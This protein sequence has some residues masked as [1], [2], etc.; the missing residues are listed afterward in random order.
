MCHVC[1]N[2]YIKLI[3]TDCRDFSVAS[4]D[5]MK[6]SLPDNFTCWKLTL[7]M[8]QPDALNITFLVVRLSTIIISIIFIQK[9]KSG[10]SRQ[11]IKEQY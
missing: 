2:L 11:M 3:T 8:F 10:K 7:L 1:D 6:G 9:S 5:M 4:V